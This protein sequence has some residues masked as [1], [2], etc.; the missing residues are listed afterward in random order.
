MLIYNGRRIAG[1]GLVREAGQD[2]H[3]AGCPSLLRASGR[4]M[5][6]HLLVG[7]AA[8]GGWRSREICQV[9]RH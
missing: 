1:G 8:I 3:I 6:G 4:E 5:T 2:E 7:H 9:N